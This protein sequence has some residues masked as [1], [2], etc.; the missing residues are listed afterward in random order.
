MSTLTIG[1]STELREAL[2]AQLID[3]LQAVDQ[4]LAGG[5]EDRD[6]QRE[7]ARAAVPALLETIAALDEIGWSTTGRPV[8]VVRQREVTRAALHEYL[9]D[10]RSIAEDA[11]SMGQGSPATDAQIPVA[12]GALQAL[13]AR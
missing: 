2:H 12:E 9:A 3:R 1:E 6:G 5:T 7:K 11:A 10:M 8:E 4:P 13:T